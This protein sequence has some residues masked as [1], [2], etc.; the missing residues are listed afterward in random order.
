MTSRFEAFLRRK[1]QMARE[2]VIP[3]YTTVDASPEDGLVAIGNHWSERLFDGPFYRSESPAADGLPVVSLVFVQS[4]DGNT[5]AADPATLGGGA[6]DFHLVYEGLSRVDADAVM[7]G[8]AT[9]RGVERVFSVWHP[10]LVALRLARGKTRHPAQVVLT[11]KGDLRFDDALFFH[12]PVLRVFVITRTDAV[13]RIR[14]RVSGRPWIDVIDAGEPVSLEHALQQ[15][16]SRGVEVLSCVGGQVTATAL[17]RERL[18]RDIYLTTSAIAGGKPDTPYYI[19]P[20]VAGYRILL[21][22]GREA[23]TGVTFEHLR[24]NRRFED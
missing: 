5:G 9:A 11:N 13:E 2:A 17:I 22:S 15:L 7:A 18:V 12:E 23:E 1:E 20:P 8:S 3:G 19:G 4:R 6:T 21:K 10:E 14:A 24:L 16:R